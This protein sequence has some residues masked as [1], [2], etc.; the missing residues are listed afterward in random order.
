MPLQLLLLLLLSLLLLLLKLT[1]MVSAV[2]CLY[3]LSL[4]LWHFLK[5]YTKPSILLLLSFIIFVYFLV[6]IYKAD[7]CY[8]L[9]KNFVV[10]IILRQR[11]QKFVSTCYWCSWVIFCISTESVVW[12]AKQTLIHPKT[13]FVCLIKLI[14]FF[15]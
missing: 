7:L 9:W 6:D 13:F 8:I 11:K 14:F 12:I 2:M 10:D 5:Y 3:L 1:E 15:F 4:L